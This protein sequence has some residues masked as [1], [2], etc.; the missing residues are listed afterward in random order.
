LVVLSCLAAGCGR[1]SPRVGPGTGTSGGNPGPPASTAGA[2]GAVDPQ[3]SS[4]WRWQ[5]CGSIPP[6]TASAVQAIFPPS[7]DALAVLYDD[8]RVL[9]YPKDDSVDPRSLRA[10]DG[11]APPVSIAFSLDGRFLAEMAAGVVRVREIATGAV[12]QEM[13]ASSACTGGNSLRFSAEGDH[14]LAWDENALCG[15]QMA[16]G[17]LAFQLA[18][19]FASAAMKGGRILAS[20]R[21]SAAPH[22]ESWSLPGLVPSE[23]ALDVSAATAL[24]GLQGVVISPRA[25][26]IVGLAIYPD[27]LSQL[28]SADGALLAA[29]PSARLTDPTFGTLVY[30]GSGALVLI[31]DQVVDVA[32]L[33]HWTNTAVD[34]QTPT[35]IDETGRQIAGVP[36]PM[37]SRAE[38]GAPAARRLFGSLPASSPSSP[39]RLPTSLS[40]STDGARLAT[41][42]SGGV[43]L[44]R[45]AP[46]F[47]ASVPIRHLDQ[48][49]PLEVSFSASSGE[50]LSSGDGW[51]VFSSD[52]GSL[53]D[54]GPVALQPPGASPVDCAFTVARFSNDGSW[55]ALGGKSPA[56][57]ILAR[58]GLQPVTALPTGHCMDRGSFSSDAR[59]L[60]L[61]GPELYRT[62]DWSLVWPAQIVPAPPATVGAE[63]FRDVQFSPDGHTL[64]VSGCAG[65][66][67]GTACTHALHSVSDGGLIRSLPELGAT[68]AHFSGEGNWIVSGR[69]VLHVP[70]GES[71]VFDANATLSTFAP[72]G[73]IVAILDDDTLARYCRTP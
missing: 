51:A 32:S 34:G 49:I 50:V 30:S 52:D 43:L 62:S 63:L 64:L 42:T 44:W 9:L 29:F 60:A 70:T 66:D 31:G 5:P 20:E 68:R 24:A 38:S 7:G 45:V 57:R 71:V 56:V 47:G 41:A 22:V 26:T 4:Q 6:M 17:A 23:I 1:A 55:L 3:V 10:A 33:Q 36:S 46:S 18:G 72:N 13:K 12:V 25:D 58:S 35:S 16:D 19:N 65:L 27:R 39:G 48:E 21:G 67:S 14:V 40:V 61:P 59:L 69:T 11:S 2:A 37:A 54:L 73:D 15:W 8:G 28:W 53:R